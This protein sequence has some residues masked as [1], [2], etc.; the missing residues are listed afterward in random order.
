MKN[1]AKILVSIFLFLSCFIINV[2]DANASVYDEAEKLVSKVCAAHNGDSTY[3]KKPEQAFM[4]AASEY[5]YVAPINNISST[6]ST[7]TE[8]L[9]VLIFNDAHSENQYHGS[10]MKYFVMSYAL[11]GVDPE[12]KFLIRFGYA[13]D[14]KFRLIETRTGTMTNALSVTNKTQNG[15]MYSSSTSNSILSTLKSAPEFIKYNLS[16]GVPSASSEK[17]YLEYT[18]NMLK[19][20]NLNNT[21]FH[22]RDEDEDP[23]NY[24]S[25]GDSSFSVDS[26]LVIWEESNNIESNSEV[27]LVSTSRKQKYK[28]EYFDKLVS[29]MIKYADTEDKFVKAY[30][31]LSQIIDTGEYDKKTFSDSYYKATKDQINAFMAKYLKSGITSGSVEKISKSEFTNW[32]DMTGRYILEDGETGVKRFKDYFNF[33]YSDMSSY[34]SK[35][36]EYTKTRTVNS[37]YAITLDQDSYDLI[38]KSINDM[39]SAKGTFDAMD[40][41]NDDNCIV[42]CSACIK[43]GKDV[44]ATAC[45][46]CKNS[47]N[48]YKSCVKCDKEAK[49]GCTS[50]DS[51]GQSYCYGGKFDACLNK[52]L[53]NGAANSFHN[54]VKKVQ[55]EFDNTLNNTID[56]L[57]KNLEQLDLYDFNDI[58]WKTVGIKIDCKDYEILRWIW[59]LITIGAPFLVIIL[60]SIDYFKSVLVTKSSMELQINPKAY[61]SEWVKNRRN[62]IRRLVALIILILLPI[63]IKLILTNLTPAG[64]GAGNIRMMQCIVNGK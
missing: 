64:N 61:E 21:T 1:K 31:N 11:K 40:A 51:A 49:D 10:Y 3:C 18:S 38:L 13:F 5:D 63:I 60:G 48:S 55:Q 12:H 53:G 47:N 50:T 46:Q 25:F 23:I 29:A 15:S 52:A 39:I 7:G 34:D 33:L 19:K 44:N 6:S 27:V 9:Q 20:L 36:G 30:L 41:F 26:H 4:G 42:Y 59:L 28:S 54:S 17:E 24:S 8:N 43:A 37:D 57:I 35:T 56:D 14:P 22:L 62:F 45:T 58:K 32:F 2:K 16:T